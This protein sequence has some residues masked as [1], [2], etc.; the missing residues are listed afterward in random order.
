MFFGQHVEEMWFA[1]LDEFSVGYTLLRYLAFPTLIAIVGSLLANIF[2]PRWQDRY[3]KRKARE[4]RRLALGEDILALM[5]IYVT[6][7]RRLIEISQYIVKRET[8]LSAVNRD[9]RESIEAAIKMAAERKAGFVAERGKTRDA[10]MNAI[11]RYRMYCDTKATELC[12]SFMNWDE[13]QSS[14]KLA[15]LPGISEWRKWERCFS[16]LVSY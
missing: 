16:D 3:L 4:E 11:S 10:L 9:D 6:N 2:L 1:K 14:K 13:A 8:E 5:N 7:W 15:E 12:N